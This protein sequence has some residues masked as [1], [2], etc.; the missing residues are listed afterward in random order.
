[1][2]PLPGSLQGMPTHPGPPL[3]L[4][5]VWQ[6]C[7][8]AGLARSCTPESCGRPHCRRHAR[9]R[10]R[11]WARPHTD[12]GWQASGCLSLLRCAACTAQAGVQVLP[13]AAGALLVPPGCRV[14]TLHCRRGLKAGYDYCRMPAVGLGLRHQL[15]SCAQGMS[16]PSRMHG[17]S[18]GEWAASLCNSRARAVG[19]QLL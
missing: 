17:V 14:L 4:W 8:C 11:T 10:A 16:F 9:P 2:G 19:V 12:I 5:C 3:G 13:Q 7:S 18:C 15:R 6:G 1:M